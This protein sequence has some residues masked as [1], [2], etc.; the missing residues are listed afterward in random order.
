MNDPCSP[1]RDRLWSVLDANALDASTAQAESAAL[2]EHLRGC[3]PCRAALDQAVRAE[4]VLFSAAVAATPLPATSVPAA[5][6]RQSS[7]ASHRRPIT[8]RRRKARGFSFLPWAAAAAV[9]VVALVALL[10]PSARS[11]A[12][13]FATVDEATALFAGDGRAVVVG[14]TLSSGGELRGGPAALRLADGTRVWLDAGSRVV[15]NASGVLRSG[16]RTGVLIRLDDGAVGISAKPQDP[17]APLVVQTPLAEAV[18]VGT[19]FRVAHDTNGSELTV[20]GGTVKLVTADGERQVSIGGH[21][22]VDAAAPPTTLLASFSAT[23]AVGTAAISKAVP[24]WSSSGTAK[25]R[26]PA[27]SQSPILRQLG[28]GHGLCFNGVDQRLST[29]I[30]TFDT[31][32]GLTLIV[33]VI[34]INPGRDQR[35]VALI[36]G[37]RERIALVRHDLEPGSIA[38]VIDGIALVRLDQP[39]GKNWSVAC[40]WHGDGSVVLNTGAGEGKRVAGVAPTAVMLPQLLF[41]GSSQGRPLEGD[42]IAVELHAGVLDD[43]ALSARVRALANANHFPITSW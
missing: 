17:L 20:T 11:S 32:H 41:G 21:V 37:G 10:G 34:P 38:A 24:G 14:M 31:R 33:L 4:R 7:T 30:D 19:A 22:R 9:V 23:S 8:V 6:P 39:K 15:L 3:A 2:L 36:D 42:I 16:G 12:S 1:W 40:R 26:A 35:V 13:T 5:R 28:A 29:A 43:A 25:A 27:G 18:V